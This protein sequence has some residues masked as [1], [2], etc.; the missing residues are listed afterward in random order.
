M[1]AKVLAWSSFGLAFLFG[2]LTLPAAFGWFG[3]FGTNKAEVVERSRQLFLFGGVPALGISLLLAL[4][5]LFLSAL[6]SKD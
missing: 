3:L 1:L 5:L 6:D 2:V 4:V